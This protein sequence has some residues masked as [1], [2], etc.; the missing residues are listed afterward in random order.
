MF[1]IKHKKM[2]AI[3]KK[4]QIKQICGGNQFSDHSK[5]IT[6]PTIGNMKALTFSNQKKQEKDQFD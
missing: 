6:I 1:L 4:I 5:N 3:S 2:N